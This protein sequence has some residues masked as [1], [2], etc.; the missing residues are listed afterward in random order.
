[1]AA[2]GDTADDLAAGAQV[3]IVHD[4]RGTGMLT[5]VCG[6][7]SH[8][9]VDIAVAADFG[10]GIDDDAAEMSDVEPR[11]DLGVV[12]NADA[13]L[14]LVVVQQDAEQHVHWQQERPLR[15][16]ILCRAHEKRVPEPRYVHHGFQEC[17]KRPAS[18]VPEKIGFDC[19]GVIRP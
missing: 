16:Q 12:G 10:L 18:V 19:A 3:N 7:D 17:R 6:S 8:F 2:E 4:N 11:T 15:L 14:I 5:S 9:M 1:M 13:V